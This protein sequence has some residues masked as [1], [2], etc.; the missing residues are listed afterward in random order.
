M[1]KIFRYSINDGEFG[2]IVV[3]SNR[4]AAIDKLIRKYNIGDNIKVWSM[5]EDEYHDFKNPDILECSG[6]L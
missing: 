1:N 5:I 2:G 4:D 3:A 6:V